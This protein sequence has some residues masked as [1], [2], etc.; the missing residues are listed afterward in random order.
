MWHPFLFTRLKGCFN[1]RATVSSVGLLI[2]EQVYGASRKCCCPMSTASVSSVVESPYI[3]AKRVVE[4]HDQISS[5]TATSVMDIVIT[6]SLA[7]RSVDEVLDSL[8]HD[9]ACSQLS[10][11]HD[12]VSQ[13]LRR[14][15]DDWKSAL[16]VFRWAMMC[17][18]FQLEHEVYDSM[19]DILGKAK[20]FGKMRELVDEM[21]RSNLVTLKTVAK[22]LRRFSGAQQWEDAVR[23]FDE[24]GTFGLEKNTE[25]M[26]LLLDTL[27]KETR[28]ER[29]REIFLELR[30]HIP[31]NAHTFNIFIHGWCRVNRVDEAHWTIQEMKGHGF[32]P[33]VV[34]YSTIMK[35][36]CQQSNYSKVHELLD[37]ME[38]QGCSANV[39][40]YTTIICW[41]TKFEQ[42]DEALK[43]AER[44]IQVGCKPDTLF[45]NALIHALGR[46]GRVKEA[47]AVFNMEMPKNGIT[48]NTSTYNTMIAMLCHHGY[49]QKALEFLKDIKE[50]PLCK[51]DLQTFHPLLKSCFRPGKVDSCLL[52]LLDGMKNEHH[53]SL[54]IS[55]YTLLIHGLCKAERFDWGYLLFKDMV[56]KELTPNYRTCRLLLDEF[57]KKS[58]YD[59]AE[60][61]EIYMKQ[62]KGSK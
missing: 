22:M 37:E 13:L 4:C 10:M 20:Q 1:G 59:P 26:N 27:C 46:A 53:L 50:S 56:D 19:V 48:P 58:M 11:T 16:G 12:L 54:D 6:K 23:T 57:K 25:S 33:C 8:V 55:T 43:I 28:V 34:S 15:R 44:M 30:S 18:D 32:H 51:P 21:R 24:L 39:V 5:L 41:L 36:Y 52:E 9:E 31:P 2:L 29:A 35:S 42:F 60:K 49:Q 61:I 38:A 47:I 45:Y 7:G 40:S 17:P 62:M 3:A 14:F